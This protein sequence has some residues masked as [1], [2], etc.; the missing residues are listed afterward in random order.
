MVSQN[1]STLQGQMQ[2][3]RGNLSEHAD[4]AIRNARSEFDWRHYVANHPWTAGRGHGGRVLPRT[5]SCLLQGR[6]FRVGNGGRR[7]RCA[8]RATIAACRHGGG[9]ADGGHGDHRSRDPGVGWYLSQGVLIRAAGRIAGT[10]PF[11]EKRLDV[12]NAESR[13]L[14]IVMRGAVM[15]VLNGK[16]M[17]VAVHRYRQ[18]VDRQLQRAEREVA[19]HPEAGLLLAAIVGILLGIWMKRT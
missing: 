17:N 4:E 12:G 16:T 1:P 11:Q 14:Q 3:I 15:N 2:E 5:A 6:Q 13:R 9:R 18:S 19:G 10:Q 7:P 8:R